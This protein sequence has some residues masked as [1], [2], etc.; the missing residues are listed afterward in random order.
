M[1]NRPRLDRPPVELP[2]LA[3]ALAV[4]WDALAALSTAAENLPW[5]LVGG[6]MVLLHGLE[7]GQ[8][9]HRVSTDIDTAV[10]VRADRGALK[11][12]TSLLGDLD[13]E[14]AGISPD[15][16]AHRFTRP[17]R[18]ASHA[19]IDVLIDAEQPD[20]GD[21]LVIDVLVPEGLSDRTNIRTVGTATAFP[22]AGVTQALA[23]TELVPV[24]IGDS[25]FWIPR[26][27]LLGALVAKAAAADTDNQ[28]V[29]RHH[30]DVVFL[31]G[32][33]EDPIAMRT[34]VGRKDGRSL[35]P[36]CLG[37]IMMTEVDNI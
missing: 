27:N 26:P 2:P 4:V 22:A 33:I 3:G 25:A 23:R 16:R 21:D 14:P 13:F 6:Q 15:G 9:P 30:R 29:E 5:T 7:C 28:D 10:D 19:V 11:R 18:P 31:A 37:A 17:I 36:S 12:L 20:T 8:T 34:D 35:A 24:T 1:G 32:L